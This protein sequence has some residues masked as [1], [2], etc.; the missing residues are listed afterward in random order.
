MMTAARFK[1]LKEGAKPVNIP[2]ADEFK[3]MLAWEAR[4]EAAKQAVKTKRAKYP[5]WPANRKKS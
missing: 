3:K 1:E 2:E 5:I 4:S